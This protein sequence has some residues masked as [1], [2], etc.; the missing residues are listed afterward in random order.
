MNSL[1]ELKV[2][3]GMTW[4]DLISSAPVLGIDLTFDYK[5]YDLPSDAQPDVD[6][7]GTAINLR[8]DVCDPNTEQPYGYEVVSLGSLE[9]HRTIYSGNTERLYDATGMDYAV[10]ELQHTPLSVNVVYALFSEGVDFFKLV[11]TSDIIDATY[12]Y[13]WLPVAIAF[14]HGR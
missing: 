2:F 14:D 4:A 12:G 9:Y 10:D 3:T 5:K 6:Y 1:N 8:S 13:Y 11:Q 7:P